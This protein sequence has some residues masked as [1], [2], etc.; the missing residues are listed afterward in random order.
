MSLRKA[1]LL[2]LLVIAGFIISIWY[3]GVVG[4]FAAIPWS[5]LIIVLSNLG[6]AGSLI[7]S[8]YKVGRGFHFWFEKNAVEKRL[9]STIGLASKKVN[10]EGIDLLPHGVDVRWVEPE[11]RDA[12]LKEGKVVVCLEPSYNE[13]RNLARATLLYVAEDLIRESQRFVKPIVMKSLDFSIARK[14]LMIDKRFSALKCLNEEFIEAEAKIEPRIRDYVTAMRRMDEEGHL[15]RILLREF[16]QLDAR[17]SPA[18]SDSRALEE[19]ENLTK[20]LK[21]F[22]ERQK[23]EDVPLRHHGDIFKINLFPIA[24]LGMD[25]DTSPYVRRASECFENRID[26]LYVLARGVNIMLAKLVIEEIEKGKLYAKREEHEF[27]IS[28]KRGGVK[29]YVGVLVR[30]AE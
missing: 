10:K 30:I 2:V 11:E 22:E 26:T 6:W 28:K 25:F 7:A 12:F 18:L 3:L 29:S 23:E 16:S 13:N 27:T 14:M 4:L 8:S 19:T 15:T 9:E 1:I 17:L 24:R 21:V 20:L 5:I